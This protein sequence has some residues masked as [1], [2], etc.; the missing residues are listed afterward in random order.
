MSELEN[1]EKAPSLLTIN[2]LAR[3]LQVKT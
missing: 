1:G 2:E 3:A